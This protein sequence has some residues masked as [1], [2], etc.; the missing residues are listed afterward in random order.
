MTPCPLSRWKLAW[1]TDDKVWFELD[2]WERKLIL[3]TAR[4]KINN[5]L[6]SFHRPHTLTS[7]KGTTLYSKHNDVCVP[8]CKERIKGKRRGEGKGV[9]ND[10]TRESDGE[11]S[12]MKYEYTVT[13]EIFTKLLNWAEILGKQAYNAIFTISLRWTIP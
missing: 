8:W 10:A 6:L 4:S 9:T 2:C 11:I 5:T 7:S 13:M 3:S 12:D 1:C